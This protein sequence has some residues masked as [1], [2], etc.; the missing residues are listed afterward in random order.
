MEKREGNAD[1]RVNLEKKDREVEENENGIRRE[2]E[3]MNVNARARAHEFAQSG[4]EGRIGKERGSEKG[5]AKERGRKAGER[6]RFGGPRGNDKRRIHRL[7]RTW[8]GRCA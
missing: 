2:K 7:V 4:G 5:R 8:P 6:R 1:E 3:G